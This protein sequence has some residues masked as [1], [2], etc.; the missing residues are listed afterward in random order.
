MKI[1]EW[2]SVTHR[3]CYYYTTCLRSRIQLKMMLLWIALVLP[4]LILATDTNWQYQIYVSSSDG[5]N[6]SSCWNGSVPCNTLNLALQGVQY[7]STVIYLYPGIYTL[8]DE[9]QVR[10]ISHVAIIGLSND[11]TISCQPLTGQWLDN[12]IFYCITLYNCPTT[13]SNSIPC[14]YNVTKSCESDN[15]ELH[16]DVDSEAYPGQTINFT[17]FLYDSC[18][19]REYVVKSNLTVCIVSG[20][21]SVKLCSTNSNCTN[22]SINSLYQY[23]FSI[24]YFGEIS[25]RLSGI[26]LTISIETL[27][28]SNYI[29][30]LITTYCPYLYAFGPNSYKLNY[31][32]HILNTK[33]GKCVL[34]SYNYSAPAC[35]FDTS[36]DTCALNRRGSLCGSCDYSV[37]INLPNECVQC[38]PLIG[39]ILFVTVQLLPVTVMVLLIIVLNI[40][41]TSG[42]INGLVFYYQ[43]ITTIYP[44]LTANALFSGSCPYIIINSLVYLL[45]P[46]N[47]DFTLFLYVYP[48][49]ISSA[50]TPLGALS[51]RYM[52]GLYP[53]VL[54]LLL[55]VWITLYDKG[56]K[57][58]VLI[59]RPI[60]RLLARFWRMANIEPS[61]PHSIASI[62]LL[63]FMQLAATSII[64]LHPSINYNGEIVFFND[65]TLHYFGWPHSFAGIFAILVLILLVLIP[66]LYIQ[67]YPF[68][69]FHKLLECLHLN[70]WQMLTSLGDVFTGSYKNGTTNKL[71]YRY[72][73]GF[74]LLLR[75][76]ILILH[77]ILN[78]DA[79]IIAQACLFGIFCGAIM[80]FR[81]HKR[82]LN[83][84]TEFFIIIILTLMSA[85]ATNQSE[86]VV[87]LVYA[88]FS[89]FFELIIFAYIIYWTIKKIRICCC[90][91]R[92]HKLFSNTNTTAT[93]GAVD[94]DNDWIADRMINPQDYDE[95][96]F[97]VAPY[98]LHNVCY[99]GQATNNN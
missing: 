81:P 28:Y 86:V 58:I 2:L 33:T 56:Y 60:H 37:P 67:L 89:L 98:Q 10:N 64:L 42:S 40:Q 82:D 53:L 6:S 76:I 20:P 63:C 11:I 52:I 91:C 93:D 22:T 19:D 96:H 69:L 31:Y 95:Q 74:Y 84:F 55:Y 12:I 79:I 80:I 85:L 50:T 65:G 68:K 18:S 29:N 66:M 34:D 41:L 75:I 30:M 5:T 57:V 88:I 3:V 48:L 59:T 94:N 78:R 15:N 99:H 77:I 90:Y 8:D 87:L 17:A 4:S 72:F 14:P 43:I 44:G 26:D 73:A 36:S 45:I 16:V 71:D 38:D 27:N 46:F 21:E 97:P 49:C 25:Y 35:Y 9:V 70:N 47:L 23:N 62:Y 1:L 83:N 7:N 13:I 51:F 92:A 61:L 24:C 32:G 54:L 39:W